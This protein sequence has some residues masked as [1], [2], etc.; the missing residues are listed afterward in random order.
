MVGR[1][2]DAA[3]LSGL[4]TLT[5][6]G[7]AGNLSDAQLLDRFLARGGEAAEAAFEALVARHGPMVLDVCR[8]VLRDPHD[9]QDAFQATF[10]VLASRAGSIRRREALAGWLLGVAR[11]IALRSRADLAR[12]R[13]CE[14]R[15]AEMR[16]RSQEDRHQ[17]WL[18]LHEEIDRLPGRYREPV[19]L[20]YLEGLSTDAAALRLGCPKGTILSRL[21]RAR[22]RLRDRLTRRGLEP[23]TGLLRA[24]GSSEAAPVAIPPGL[25]AATVRASLGFAEQPAAATGLASTTTVTLARKV[26]YAMMVSKLKILGAAALACV[27]TLVSIHTYARQSGGTGK[28]PAAEQ[29]ADERG[30]GPGQAHPGQV[31]H[32]SSG[33]PVIER[34]G[35]HKRVRDF[36]EQADLSTPEAAQAAWNR[37]S[38]RMDDRAV[39][40]LSW[41]KWGPRDIEQMKRLRRSNP[42]DAAVYNAAQ[43]DAEILEVATYREDLADVVT[44]L[45]F[46]E[47]VGRNPYSSRSFGRIDGVWKNLGEDRLPSL[48]AARENF[49]RKKEGLWQDYLRVRDSVKKGRTVSAGRESGGRGAR[50][51]PGEPLGIS[52][53]KADL[54]GR[55]EWAMMHGGRDITERKSIEWGEIERDGEGNRTIRYKYNAT[56]WD[57]DIFVMNQVF[58]F[59]A[60]GN[61]LDREDVEGFPQKK[62][63]KSVN[64]NT[65]EGMK[66][67]VED[68]FGKNFRDI[69]AREGIEW[70]EVVK[71]ANGNSSIRYK[72]RAR[73][74]GSDTR[75]MNQVFTFDPKGQF[76]SVN[77]VGGFPRDR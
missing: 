8:Q 6:V 34:R 60:K 29:R 35:I 20:C 55:V 25:L 13:A 54:L 75:I 51:A 37:A 11:R 70:G 41:I 9:V 1:T 2:A 71:T 57:K 26:V 61:I 43:R 62:V 39:L 52:V 74:G 58:T 45:S 36:S 72:Y 23:A 46:P 16:A 30:A 19:V 22:E 67:L 18:E 63:E 73:I 44:K 77:D 66:E 64:V 12:R 48:E 53:E 7:V 4:N 10:L 56:I 49:D 31:A 14:G 38:A 59:D 68:F 47:G 24:G 33:Q 5:H 17:T 76:V 27:L 40:E 50:I 32:K 65:R 28:E 42:R 69:T 15:A 3:L 21:S